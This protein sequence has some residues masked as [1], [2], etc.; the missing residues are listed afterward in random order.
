MKKEMD[1]L[2]TLKLSNIQNLH[3]SI[4][5]INRTGI[6]Q[7]ADLVKEL[8]KKKQMLI[9]TIQ[10]NLKEC[11]QVE[12]TLF[13]QWSNQYNTEAYNKLEEYN[14]FIKQQHDKG[15]ELIGVIN[16]A[17]NFQQLN[18][19]EIGSVNPFINELKTKC[20]IYARHTS[21]SSPVSTSFSSLPTVTNVPVRGVAT[22][23]KTTGM[24]KTDINVQHGDMGTSV[25]INKEEALGSPAHSVRVSGA[26]GPVK[27]THQ[28]S[29][30]MIVPS[31]QPVRALSTIVPASP[32]RLVQTAPV[33]QFQRVAVSPVR[34]QPVRYVQPVQQVQ[35]V[36]VVQPVQQV[37]VVQ[38][39]QPVR[40]V[41]PVQQ[42]QPVR[43]V[44]PVQTVP[45]VT[46]LPVGAR[47]IVT[48]THIP[49]D[50]NGDKLAVEA[51]TVVRIEK[52]Y[53]DWALVNT[54]TGQRGYVSK[55]YLRNI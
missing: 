1:S 26:K 48:H 2:Q 24:G 42:V 21:F 33:Q 3:N 5:T 13:N 11:R 50:R 9:E 41:Q 36:R 7:K 20:S 39:V 43:Y 32:V 34:V 38:P 29:P 55:Y 44:Q 25:D 6:E 17:K 14:L 54:S 51:G 31:P 4:D 22:D 27:V 37:R 12:R 18:Q 16:A 45:V 10:E 15:S 28:P 53:G 30:Q 46:T 47:A 35:P 40:V 8:N 19:V 49:S 52:Y 23:I